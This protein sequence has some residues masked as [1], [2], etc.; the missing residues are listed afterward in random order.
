M[1]APARSRSQYLQAVAHKIAS[2]HSGQ[3]PQRLHTLCSLVAFLAYQVTINY[4]K[5]QYINI[6][7]GTAYQLQE[8]TGHQMQEGAVDFISLR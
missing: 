1:I 2:V 5:V 3:Q 8:G 4:R 7:G 6:Q